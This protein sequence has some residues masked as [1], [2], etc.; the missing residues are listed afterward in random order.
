MHTIYIT[1]FNILIKEKALA[2]KINVKIGTNAYRA[3]NLNIEKI[4]NLVEVNSQYFLYDFIFSV[5]V[6]V[7]P[8][9]GQ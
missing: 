2:N 4:L 8:Q 9:N 3:I 1:I 6:K 5:L 7:V